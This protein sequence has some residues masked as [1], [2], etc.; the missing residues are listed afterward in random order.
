MNFAIYK[1]PSS[2]LLSFAKKFIYF[3]SLQYVS[4][5]YAEKRAK[6][7][8]DLRSVFE[9][10]QSHHELLRA[11]LE[12]ERAKSLIAKART[13][14]DRIAILKQKQAGKKLSQV[15][16]AALSWA[17][18]DIQSSMNQAERRRYSVRKGLIVRRKKKSFLGNDKSG[19]VS[20][21]ARTAWPGDT[22]KFSAKFLYSKNLLNDDKMI[23]M[24]D[25]IINSVL[26]TRNRRS[27]SSIPRRR[28]E[29]LT[30]F[31]PSSLSLDDADPNGTVNEIS[32]A[33]GD[34]NIHIRFEGGCHSSCA[35]SCCN[36][37][38]LV[39]L[40]ERIVTKNGSPGSSGIP[41]ICSFRSFSS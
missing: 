5:N 8:L 40:I 17:I 10:A 19:L 38:A 12:D 4:S 20:K 31:Y 26:S 34:G 27:R 39:D 21:I 7:D 3:L 13:L 15:S 1:P 22:H 35:P 2:F 41:G 37:D 30:S 14:S 24:D 28:S 16:D 18:K 9:V 33:E 36:N 32:G 29:V 23:A 6:G 11:K 25:G